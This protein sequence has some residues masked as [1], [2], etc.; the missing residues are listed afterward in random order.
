METSA[1][2]APYIEAAKGKSLVNGFAGN[3]F[4]PNTQITRAEVLKIILQA[5]GV[6]LS[7]GATNFSD[8]K[9]TDWYAPYIAYASANGIVGGYTDGTFGPNKPITRADIA[10]IIVKIWDSR[11]Q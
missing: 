9:A 6:K 10:K 4:K 7:L 8:V 11:S 2:Y 5:A 3:L 1:W